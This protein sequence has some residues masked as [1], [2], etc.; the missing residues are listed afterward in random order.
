LHWHECDEKIRFCEVDLFNVAWHGHYIKY[1]EIGRLD[2]A[3]KFGMSPDAMKEMGYYVPV[4]DLGCR[5]REPARLGDMITIKTSVEPV[6]KAALT[7]RYEVVRTR[8]ST[9]LAEGFTSHVL[10]TLD[11]KMIY[12]IPERLK[13]P[14]EDMLA[15][16]ND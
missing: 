9:L 13:K 1:F 7:F 8:D 4:V 11:G 2:L 14:L 10:L 3:G 12:M 5:F 15:Y 16:C 6:E